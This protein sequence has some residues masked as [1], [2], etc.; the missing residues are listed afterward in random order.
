[1]EARARAFASVNLAIITAF[2]N[3]ALV[4]KKRVASSQ[5]KGSRSIKT[6]LRYK[7][8]RHARTRLGRACLRA[9]RNCVSPPLYDDG[10]L[11][12]ALRSVGRGLLKGEASVV[13]GDF[14]GGSC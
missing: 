11:V 9:Q 14:D 5:E 1:M 6:F 12:L 4:E 8:L 13:R 3:P 10:E 2:P 7:P